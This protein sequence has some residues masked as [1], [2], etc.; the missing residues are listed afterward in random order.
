MLGQGSNPHPGVAE[1]H[2]SHCATVGTPPFLILKG[3]KKEKYHF[4]N[5]GQI[6]LILLKC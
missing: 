6:H 4:A 1:T 3:E 5:L 2:R